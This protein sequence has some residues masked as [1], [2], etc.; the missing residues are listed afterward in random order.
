M[1]SDSEDDSADL[2]AVGLG[3]S[4]CTA[5]PQL[6]QRATVMRAVGGDTKAPTVFSGAVEAPRVVEGAAPKRLF[7]TVA[8][9]QGVR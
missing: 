5:G 7:P 1:R 2:L 4:H 6:K 8:P 9:A 3:F